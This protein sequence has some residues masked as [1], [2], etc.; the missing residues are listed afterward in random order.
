MQY[1]LKQDDTINQMYLDFQK[2]YCYRSNGWLVEF[3]GFK[4][5]EGVS[6]DYVIPIGFYRDFQKFIGDKPISM[7]Y[8][9][10]DKDFRYGF[11][12]P[13]TV[14]TYHDLRDYF[15]HTGSEFSLEAL[16]SLVSQYFHKKPIGL[17]GKAIDK[18]FSKI[19]K[20]HKSFVDR[21][22][23]RD[24]YRWYAYKNCC[25]KIDAIVATFG[26]TEDN[27]L[28]KKR[29]DDIRTQYKN[30]ERLTVRPYKYRDN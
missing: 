23:H 26:I 21:L 28:D 24:M 12:C 13:L 14:E 10:D 15:L 7:V 29:I 4:E 9:Y 6:I 27:S 22:S 5:I 8:L 1:L 16:D 11:V 20:D 17:S 18:A 19:K 30:W 3:Y 25:I 2:A